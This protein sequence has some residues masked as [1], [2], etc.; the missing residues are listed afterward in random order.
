[1]CNGLTFVASWNVE[2]LSEA[3]LA[4]LVVAMEQFSID[5]LCLQESRINNT[6][7]RILDNDFL[8]MNSGADNDNIKSFQLSF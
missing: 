2:G 5:I 4:E 3:K 6:E 7:I 1:M 8:L